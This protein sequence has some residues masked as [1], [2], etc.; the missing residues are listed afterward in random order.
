METFQILVTPTKQAM[1]RIAGHEILAIYTADGKIGAGV[2]MICDL[3]G[4]ARP[5]QMHKLQTDPDFRDCLILAK[6]E[7]AGQKRLAYFIIAEFIPLW[8]KGIHS[9][10][11]APQARETLEEFRSVAVETLRAFFSPETRA[12][13]QSAPPKPPPSSPPAQDASEVSEYDMLRAVI[14]RMEEKDRQKEARFAHQ[15]AWLARLERKQDEELAQVWAAIRKLSAAPESRLADEHEE[16]LHILLYCAHRITS[17]PMEELEREALAAAG[18]AEAGQVRE[19]A[20]NRVMAWLLPL[21][22]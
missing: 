3:L 14:H 16:M 20:W 15:E 7:I 17:Q 12:K 11:V 8:L 18:V 19:A 4:L 21:L 13:Q 9:S 22:G 5:P 6:V 1:V 2:R 10:K